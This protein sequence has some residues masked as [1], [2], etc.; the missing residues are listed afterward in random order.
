MWNPGHDEEFLAHHI[1]WQELIP[2][3]EAE[4]ERITVW[5]W[6][7]PGRINMVFRLHDGGLIET[8]M[9]TPM[10]EHDAVVCQT[11]AY[12]AGCTE[13]WLG[14]GIRIT[15]DVQVQPCLW[16]PDLR[17]PLRSL[18]EGGPDD[19]ANTALDTH[20]AGDLRDAT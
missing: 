12:R 19:P 4:I 2:L 15:P 13:G 6:A 9:S 14:C 17:F 3:W 11:C 8:N 5:D 18:I 10:A 16:R 20:L 7:R 1:S